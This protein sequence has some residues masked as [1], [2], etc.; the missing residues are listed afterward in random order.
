M[1]EAKWR[2]ALF[3]KCPKCGKGNLFKSK[4]PYELKK[5]LDMYDACPNCKE[6]FVVENGFYYGA[7]YMSYIITCAMCIAILPA[8]TALNFSREKFLDN[9]GWYIGSCALLL[10]LTTPYVTQLSRALWLTIHIK[11]FKKHSDQNY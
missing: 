3:L 7:M 6:D 2:N 1:S 10:I 8:Y 5:I 9:A 4:H 11:Y